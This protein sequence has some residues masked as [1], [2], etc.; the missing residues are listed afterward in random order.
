MFRQIRKFLLISLGLMVSW[1]LLADAE[2]LIVPDQFATITSALTRAANNT[3]PTDTIVL[4]RGTYSGPVELLD[5]VSLRGDETARTIIDGGGVSGAVITA[6]S[7]STIQR[8]TIRNGEIGIAFPG[9]S[10]QIKSVK[11]NIIINNTSGIECTSAT[12]ITI[13]YNTFNNNGTAI[14]C[15]SST[16][17]A[18]TNNIISNNTTSD[19]TFDQ[20]TAVDYNL[21]Y[22]NATENY[23]DTQLRNQDLN[24]THNIFTPKVGDANPDFVD[25]NNNDFHL[26][27]GSPAIG[28][29]E[30]GTEIGV[31]GGGNTDPPFSVSNLRVT[32]GLNTITVEWDKNLAYN[33]QGYRVYYDSDE[34][35]PPYA[36]QFDPGNVITSQITGLS[37]S[38]T[39]VS[40]PDLHVGIGD[41]QLLLYWP[42]SGQASVVE[43]KVYYG[44][45]SGN[46]SAPGSPVTITG[47]NSS[48]YLLSNLVNE[49]TYY[50]AISTI[51][52]PVYFVT[53]AVLD[54]QSGQSDYAPVQETHLTGNNVESS[55]STEIS[56]TPEPIVRFPNLPNEG[57]ECFIATA[58][59][60]SPLE[61]HVQILRTFRDRH[62]LTNS[63]GRKF[64]AF[65]YQT[66][67][68]LAHWLEE[69]AS[70]KPVVRT[71][72]S[73]IVFV[74]EF[75]MDSGSFSQIL[76]I[77][78]VLSLVSYSVYR[79]GILRWGGHY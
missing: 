69:H 23:V 53:V 15:T 31:Y 64:V 65:Y 63:L 34:A 50:M 8:L 74:T 71:F 59:Y 7:G 42:P 28:T 25:R 30:N 47:R 52:A 55:L 79:R 61:P 77:V 32:P 51:A 22:N 75:W 29:G 1:P 60:G 46:Y 33:V 58:A 27:T 21:F 16:T 36:Q 56:A 9:T 3:D 78:L 2:D 57:L 66:S 44:T 5:N 10:T 45:A 6:G 67:P 38:V 72:L 24:Q 68:P 73:P 14:T 26:Q 76:I 49:T 37:T 70:F 13:S 20:P 12:G 17:V 48:S 11:N 39:A 35:N 62:L 54:N 41:T 43:Y 18:I 4:R 40:P 19:I